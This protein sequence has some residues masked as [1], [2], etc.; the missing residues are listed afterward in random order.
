MKRGDIL[1]GGGE[2]WRVV[3]PANGNRTVKL[4]QI[5]GPEMTEVRV[6]EVPKSFFHGKQL[7]RAINELIDM[8]ATIAVAEISRYV[9][10]AKL[11]WNP[12]LWATA[13]LERYGQDVI[14]IDLTTL[15]G[16]TSRMISAGEE[17]I[18]AEQEAAKKEAAKKRRSKRLKLVKKN[19]AKRVVRPR[20]EKS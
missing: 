8:D 3:E 4:I 5:A 1:V 20:G 19:S 6:S 12:R 16:W 13:L 14:R 9:D 15:L 7:Y 2:C 11:G 18:L 17:K 10:V